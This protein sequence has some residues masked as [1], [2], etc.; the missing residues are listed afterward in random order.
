M[1]GG[2]APT[3]T[4]VRP[5]AASGDDPGQHA[6]RRA[7]VDEKADLA[8]EFTEW[9]VPRLA[10]GRLRPSSTGSCR[11]TEAAEAHRAVGDDATVGKVVLS[12]A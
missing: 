8:A 12:V 1:V 4:S 10:D 6:A 11:W 5:P 3:S 7:R 2:R 9:G